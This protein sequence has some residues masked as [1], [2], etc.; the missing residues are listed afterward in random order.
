MIR[1]AA[2]NHRDVVV[3]AAKKEYALL[4]SL[5]ADQQGVTS[6]EQRRAFAIKAFDVCTAY[7]MAISNY[8]HQTHFIQP[9]GSPETVLRYGENPQQQGV[10]Y[11]NTEEL[12]EQL[13]G[14]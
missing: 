7:D 13:N 5:L 12:F 4:E 14:K 10:F 2:K 1:A 3:I 9:F 11:G 8:F 6:I